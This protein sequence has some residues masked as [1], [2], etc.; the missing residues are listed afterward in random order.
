ML[1]GK[2]L[3]IAPV[4]TDSIVEGAM[5]SKD[6]GHRVG[7]HRQGSGDPWAAGRGCLTAHQ[8]ICSWGSGAGPAVQLLFWCEGHP[9][10]A[11]R[12]QESLLCDWPRGYGTLVLL[13]TVLLFTKRSAHQREKSLR[14]GTSFVLKFSCLDS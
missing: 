2:E 10:G 4:E 5:D 11:L 13:Y 3:H 7:G 1:E 9:L 14:A 8:G 6:S 12:Q